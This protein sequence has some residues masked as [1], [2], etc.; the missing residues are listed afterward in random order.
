MKKLI[1]V[2]TVLFTGITGTGI[3][4]PVI[5]EQT[6]WGLR[7]LDTHTF[8]ERWPLI[9]IA[10]AMAIVSGGLAD[11]WHD[12]KVKQMAETRSGETTWNPA[13]AWAALSLI[14]QLLIIRGME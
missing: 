7:Y 2:L 4:F 13:F 12:Y 9:I 3:L 11:R 1:Y 6:N 10:V 14:I 8:F 5:L